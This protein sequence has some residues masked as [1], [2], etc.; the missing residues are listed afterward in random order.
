MASRVMTPALY[1][2]EHPYG[3]EIT[4]A[5]VAKLTRDAIAKFHDTWYRPN[6]TTLVIVGDTT[7][8]EIKPQLEKAFASW[9]QGNT[10]KKS[11]SKV[12]APKQAEVYL[13][14]KPGA[15]Q[16]FILAATIATQRTSPPGIALGNCTDVL[17]GSV[18]GPATLDLLVA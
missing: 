11:I 18:R 14:D 5:G 1:G 17:G 8:A 3:L 7:L 15:A 9:K 4:E 16:S 10:P 13:I 6:N 12:A 2:K